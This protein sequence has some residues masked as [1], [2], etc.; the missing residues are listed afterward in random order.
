LE[1]SPESPLGVAIFGK[2]AGEVVK[3][4]LATGRKEVKIVKVR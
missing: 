4:R 1:I 3:M 2:K